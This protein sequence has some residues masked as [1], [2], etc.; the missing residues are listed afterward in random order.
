MTSLAGALSEIVS[1]AFEEADLP[2]EFGLVRVSDRPD[3]AQFQCNGAMTAARTAKKNP[4]QVAQEVVDKLARHKPSIIKKLE[5]AGPGF[6]NIDVSDE[7][8]SARLAE[9][10]EDKKLGIA[11]LPQQDTAV[12][13][14][15]GPNIAKPMHIGHL[16]AGIIGD[17]LRRIMGFAGYKTLGDVHMGDWGTHLGMLF[18][19]Y[20]RSGEENRIL[21]VDLEDR[22][23]VHDLFRDM[24]E[25]YPKASAA[26]KADEALMKEAHEATLKMQN[27][28]APWYPMWQ[29]V[30]A[31][32]IIGMKENYGALNVGFDLWKGESDVH[33]LIA[34]MVEELEKKG[35]A[36]ESEGALVVPV[37]RNDD[38]KEVP[39]LILY[40]RD[41]AVMYG[42]TDLA[43]LVERIKL[44]EPSKII[45]IVDQR[46]HLHFEQ[47]FRAAKMSGI[48]PE[49]VELT[50]VGF[51]TMNGPD[52]KPFK[53]R[54]GGVLRLDDLINMGIEKAT[55]RLNEAHLAED[56]PQAEREE[57]ARLVAVAA[58][59]F[60]D[61]QNN[62]LS[63]YIF[64]LDR[65]TSLEGKT[66]PYLLYQAVRIKSLLKKA[67]ER[68]D[69]PEANSIAPTDIDRPLALMLCEFPDVFEGA[70]RNYTPHLLCDY[71]YRLSQQFSSFYNACHILSEENDE[72]RNSRLALCR[73]TLMQLETILSLLGIGVPERM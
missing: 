6:I 2:G 1:K 69:L 29:K 38:N 56:M 50:H 61:L 73:M 66:G 48:V 52:G 41:G 32:S 55:Q 14:Y 3:L 70:V 26:A 58:I 22:E 18:N 64:D 31:V 24:S 16:R 23:A 19:D 17:T 51:G 35:F 30:R 7:Y 46:Q 65:F 54:A 72:L 36:V 10:S 43:T 67:A 21:D 15:G 39:P 28:E 40:K 37:K 59:K 42:T 68:V 47:V 5:I 4:R 63:D 25:R 9:I 20:L 71:A 49:S 33:E 8:L 12:L 34:P 53:T 60:A 13:D 44:Y 11:E 57:V 62:P 27:K 45:Y